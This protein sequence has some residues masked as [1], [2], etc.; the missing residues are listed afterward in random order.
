VKY[1]F[2]T[3]RFI[4]AAAMALTGA[5]SYAQNQ[6]AI[7]VETNLGVFSAQ[8]LTGSVG[9]A[10]PI[11]PW[12]SA[13]IAFSIVLLAL[14]RGW[15][16]DRAD[17]NRIASIVLAWSISVG[18]FFAVSNIQ[19]VHAQSNQ[20]VT[21]N[22]SVVVFES[23]ATRKTATLTATVNVNISR[24]YVT[25]GFTQSNNCGSSVAQGQSCT[26]TIDAQ[27]SNNG[28]P[29]DPG[30]NG[31]L[32]VV[33]IDSNSNGVRDDVERHIVLTLGLTGA[34]AKS[35][36]ELAAAQQSAVQVAT[37]QAA[38]LVSEPLNK[39][40]DCLF[41]NSGSNPEKTLKTAREITG[42]QLNTPER[43]RAYTDFEAFLAGAVFALSTEPSSCAQ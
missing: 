18:T 32:T 31:L 24:I 22:P 38:M 10:V 40:V 21:L 43:L 9:V 19:Y 41:F 17:L 30:S 1:K 15:K 29:P 12:I 39:S 13:L 7:F 36:F 2:S 4:T 11:A 23:G 8:I 3:G 42:F 14:K 33:G 34:E 20:G 27:S 16:S 5:D 6:S 37:K 25:G 26:I 28:L 35:A